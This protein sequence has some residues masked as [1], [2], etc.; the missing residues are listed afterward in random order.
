MKVKRILLTGDDGYNSIGIRALIHFLRPQYELAIAGTFSQQSGVGG[1]V[2]VAHGGKWG[3][4]KVDGVDAFWV[5]GFP[6]DAIEGAREYYKEPFDLI[7]SG[8]N[9]GA[10]IG[11][12]LISSGT[13]SAAY[14][15]VAFE[16]GPRAIV[17]SWES[18]ASV[19]YKS[20]SHDDDISEFLAY[21]GD[22]AEK[23]FHLAV[24]NDFWNAPIVNIN[25]PKKK[26]KRAIFTKLL[27]NTIDYYPP[28]RLSRDD[29]TFLYPHGDANQAR[30]ARD[31]DA[32]CHHDEKKNFPWC[33]PK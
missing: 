5:D 26:A 20:H 27:A 7:I 12:A 24:D 29:H 22:V 28:V 6:C 13:F 1:H 2:S 23:L 30:I 19:W 9:F 18:P 10:N 14:L 17:M 11:S 32:N 25:F 16:I 15:G 3:E 21:P 8:I 31:T 33:S 4:T